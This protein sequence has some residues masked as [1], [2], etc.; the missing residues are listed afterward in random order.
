MCPN[1]NFNT[2]NGGVESMSCED[3]MHSLLLFIDYELI[4]P[5]ATTTL[6]T[7]FQEC[8]PCNEEM[9]H[10]QKVLTTLKALLAR[11]CNEEAPEDLCA[12]VAEQT[13]QLAAAMAAQGTAGNIFG[14][15][16]SLIPGATTQITTSYSRTEV[17]ID[18]QTH[19]EIETSHEI[20]HEF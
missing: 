3:A 10:E 20:R 14:G 4:N 1:N 5:V 18:G 19:I 11:E 12:K 9:V 2:S 13:A 16:P 15:M 17:T 8:P 6:A 7:H